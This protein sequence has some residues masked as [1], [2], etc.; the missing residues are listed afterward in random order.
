MLDNANLCNPSV[1][2]RL[3]PLLEPQ[4]VLYLNECGTGS[5]GPRIISPH[6]NFRLFLTMNAKH[7]EV[8]RAMRNRGLELFL[9]PDPVT[10]LNE[11]V[12][13]S[14]SSLQDLETVASLQGLPGTLLP[15]FMTKVH[16]AIRE[17][18]VSRHRY[19]LIIFMIVCC[20][21]IRKLIILVFF[22]LNRRAPAIRELI[23]WAA[24][25]RTLCA[26]GLKAEFASLKAFESI[27]LQPCDDSYLREAG[28]QA[29]HAN[30][31]NSFPVPWKELW[32]K[33]ASWPLPLTVS[34]F[35][36]DSWA[37]TA[38]RDLAPILYWAGLV[39]NRSIAP[40]SSIAST[41]VEAE[42]NALAISAIL[43]AEALSCIL[44]G[45]SVPEEQQLSD[46]MSE[47]SVAAASL[48][49]AVQVL[50]ERCDRQGFHQA[51]A[52][53][54]FT[55]CMNVL[56]ADQV[57][58][59]VYGADATAHISNAIQCLAAYFSSP[60]P[61]NEPNSA[62]LILLRRALSIAVSLR[63]VAT[64]ATVG[65]HEASKSLLQLSCW[66][67]ENPGLR[68]KLA[69]PHP[70]V[71]WLWPLFIAIQVCEESLLGSAAVNWDGG[72]INK[73]RRSF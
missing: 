42:N 10:G 1:L 69:T 28:E 16:C 54:T 60:L 38:S 47:A 58:V 6:P 29:Y 39:L 13:E 73:V 45:K 20:V 8:S 37:A 2:D 50:T 35:S 9:L 55:S 44:L 43:P 19:V 31:G 3:N 22:F 32:F 71:D 7:G 25:T 11:E 62:K 56:P 27:Y 67:F 30:Y 15:R 64:Q 26:R 17:E 63:Q 68:N 52:A 23:R 48:G 34:A 41:D 33:P 18:T 65:I 57:E 72:L 24:M 46:V 61:A 53:T 59:S 14:Y 49:L 70:M 40:R 4:G 5:Q 66:R 36:A 51:W 21:S 12:D